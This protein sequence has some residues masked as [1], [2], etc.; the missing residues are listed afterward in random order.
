MCN[1]KENL[2]LG[3]FLLG[4]ALG[5]GLA[6]LYAPEKG[7]DTRRK[8]KEKGNKM[9]DDVKLGYDKFHTESQKAVSAVKDVADKAVNQ[10]KNLIETSKEKYAA[11]KENV[12]EALEELNKEKEC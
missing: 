4:M 2:G 12:E 9:A 8:L 10:I 7:E 6:L 3:S 11:K 5:A 1:K